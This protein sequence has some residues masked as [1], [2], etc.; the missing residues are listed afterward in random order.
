MP[1]R[2]GEDRADFRIALAPGARYELYIEIGPDEADVPARN[3]YRS[4][5]ARARFRMRRSR[6]QGGGMRSSGRLFDDWMERSRA[7]LAL[8]TTQL[9]TG[10]FPYAGIPWFSDAVRARRN[11]HLA[12][13]SLARSRPRARR[14]R[15]SC[16]DAG[17]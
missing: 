15:L 9:P 10:P 6:R 1:E 2:I 4:A 11:H 5:A 14:A 8:L 3:R 16:A 12:A 13:D 7:D 17:A